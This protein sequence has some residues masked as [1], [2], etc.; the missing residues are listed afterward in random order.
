M[1]NRWQNLP[2]R[3][4]NIPDSD[5]NIINVSAGQGTSVTMGILWAGLEVDL[6]CCVTVDV[7]FLLVACVPDLVLSSAVFSFI[8]TSFSDF[9]ACSSNITVL[10]SGVYP[11]P[12]KSS[13]LLRLLSLRDDSFSLVLSEVRRIQFLYDM[14]TLD[15]N[16]LIN[17]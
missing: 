10:P 2:G 7:F 14:L 9:A 15:I 4:I 11:L 8:F 6:I 1:N 16:Q 5:A 13:F 12:S 17:C 3:L